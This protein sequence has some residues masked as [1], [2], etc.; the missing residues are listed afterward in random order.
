M[1]AVL[2]RTLPPSVQ[3]ALKSVGYF[4]QD[5]D[6]TPTEKVNPYSVSGQGSRSFFIVLSLDGSV[7]P[8]TSFGSWGGANPFEAKRD[9]LDTL[10][11]NIPL[12]GAVIKGSKGDRVFATLYVNPQNVAPLLPIKTDLSPRQV[13]ILTIIRG[14]KSAYRKEWYQTTFGGQPSPEEFA[15]LQAKG[16]VKINKA[17]SISLTTEG[18]NACEGE[19]V[20]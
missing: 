10:E 17:G 19:R 5:I 16:L 12:G 18:K 11:Y 4:C 20:Y 15:T 9:D 2:T 8:I 1:T 14:I 6:T 7:P 3:E 13:K